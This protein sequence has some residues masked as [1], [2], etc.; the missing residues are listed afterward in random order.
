MSKAYQRK[1]AD[2]V[3]S[4]SAGNG[5]TA[6]GETV[7]FFAQ[8]LEESSWTQGIDDIDWV[9]LKLENF[10]SLPGFSD[11]AEPAVATGEP[12]GELELLPGC[13]SKNLDTA[14]EDVFDSSPAASAEGCPEAGPDSTLP[15]DLPQ[16]ADIP[17]WNDLYN[18]PEY[19]GTPVLN[20]FDSPPATSTEDYP[21][22][23]SETK[24]QED[25]SQD[26]GFPWWSGFYSPPENPDTPV[27]NDFDGLP[28]GSTVDYFD[29]LVVEAPTRNTTW[30]HENQNQRVV[31]PRQKRTN[32]PETV[33]NESVDGDNDEW[34]HYGWSSDEAGEPEWQQD[35]YVEPAAEFLPSTPRYQPQQLN[36]NLKFV[37]PSGELS[38]LLRPVLPAT[39]QQYLQTPWTQP[40]VPT[41][42]LL[43]VNNPP[44]APQPQ[45]RHQPY[46]PV[47]SN[48]NG[49]KRANSLMNNDNAPKHEDSIVSQAS[50]CADLDERPNKRRREHRGPQPLT[51]ST[52]LLREKLH[53][54]ERAAR[55]KR[56]RP[57]SQPH[58]VSQEVYS[59]RT[60][61]YLQTTLEYQNGEGNPFQQ[62]N[63]SQDV[64]PRPPRS[65]NMGW[66]VP[67]AQDP[68]WAN[69]RPKERVRTPD[70]IQ[71]RPSTAPGNSTPRW[72]DGKAVRPPRKVYSKKEK[73]DIY[74]GLLRYQDVWKDGKVDHSQ[75]DSLPPPRPRPGTQWPQ[76]ENRPERGLGASAQ[77]PI[78]D[79]GE[80]VAEDETPSSM[81][82][83][84]R[85]ANQPSVMS[86]ECLMELPG[87]DIFGNLG[88]EDDEFMAGFEGESGDEGS[89][90]GDI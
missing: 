9:G 83:R 70:Q 19:P 81:M 16:D 14:V 45:L 18:P 1:D 73:E 12:D 85:L 57:A 30:R 41:Y 44:R 79:L 10:D 71:H 74:L 87:E 46:L 5:N 21:E 72:S 13:S 25:H 75:L 42:G 60:E 26:F 17:W 58:Q 28:N 50:S 34:Q 29:N 7:D 90:D 15:G 40:A 23:R 84:L 62:I 33:R 56:R 22:A 89:E 86:K 20:D 35:W 36:E 24:L 6:N 4:T 39:R 32:N 69:N 43:E 49:R 63:P 67:P 53:Q 47:T 82:D 8:F 77:I 51:C 37:I 64:V 11:Q 27:L 38:E 2:E 65:A 76:W 66:A 80:D 48:H 3:G 54:A 88:D 78:L 31:Q 52:H 55:A 59:Q 61:P 68:R